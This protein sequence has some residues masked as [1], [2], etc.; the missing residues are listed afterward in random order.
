MKSRIFIIAAF[1]ML[2]SCTADRNPVPGRKVGEIYLTAKGGSTS[3]LVKTEDNWRV[4]T[5]ETWLSLDVNG[6]SGESAFTVSCESNESDFVNVNL[7][8]KGAVVICNLRTMA[9]DTL[10]I[11]QQG[12]PDGI[13]RHS[14]P[15]DS[16]IEFVDAELKRL[17]VIYANFGA[18]TD[19]AAVETWISASDADVVAG[20][21]KETAVLQAREG[22]ETYE[23]LF[24]L[25]KSGTV[26]GRTQK[27]DL[28]AALA[29]SI[30]GKMIQVSDFPREAPSLEMI[31]NLMDSGYDRA[32][33][34]SDW[35]IGGSFYFLSSMELSCPD[36]PQWYPSDISDPSFEA[37]RYAQYN[38][39]TDC[40]W[41]VSRHFNPTW[42]EDGK[43][44]RA[45]YVYASNSVWNTAVDVKLGPEPVP[46]SG[47]RTI[48]ISLKY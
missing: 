34:G 21:W 47:H 14:A 38:N 15:Q 29:V 25:D 48:E 39:L 23:D 45:D 24:I 18:C 36:T 3:V 6:G 46:G 27:T 8:R 17:K 35:L 7:S 4:W 1:L 26:S 2:C 44:W 5:D 41:M 22:L 42:T 43:S 10:Y 32:G 28:P 30:D 37:D 19:K 33:S 31:R 20:I 12:I 16:Y 40:I 11:V 13:E 9:P